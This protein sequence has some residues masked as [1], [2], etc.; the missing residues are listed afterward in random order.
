MIQQRARGRTGIIMAAAVSAAFLVWQRVQATRF[1]YD[2][3][4]ARTQVRR[5][6]GQL[7]SK[8]MQWEKAVAPAQLAHHA[9]SRLGMQQGL[10]ESVRILQRDGPSGVPVLRSWALPQGLAR[11]VRQTLSALR[12]AT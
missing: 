6:Q 9:R 4:E 2:V 10:P 1:G 11:A 8:G 5:L 3:E 7:L 12:R